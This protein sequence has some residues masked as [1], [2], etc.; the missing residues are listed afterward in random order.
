MHQSLTI[1]ALRVRSAKTAI[2]LALFVFCCSAALGDILLDGVVYCDSAHTLSEMVSL[3][4]A[5]DNQGL[6]K[7]IASGHVVLKDIP[8]EVLAR[9]EE[10]D[11][12]L[13]FAFPGSPTTYWTLSRWVT[14]EPKEA[15]SSPSS[16]LIPL[17]P[18]TV[19]EVPRQGATPPFDDQGG[20]IIW[21]QV[22]GK[23]KWRPRDPAHFEHFKGITPRPP[24]N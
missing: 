11:S 10:P 1:H 3:A 5:G 22:D 2:G 6:A 21:H 19:A 16:T 24:E 14:P 23:W 13:E 8:V 9:G 12:P 4:R 7:M 18:K 15:P 20:E 17:S